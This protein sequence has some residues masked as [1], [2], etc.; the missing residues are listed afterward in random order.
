LNWVGLSLE[1]ADLGARLR[2]R[3][4]L[5]TPDA[6]ILATAIHSRATGFIGNDLRLSR[7]TEIDTMVLA[8]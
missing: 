7:V 5:K 3:Y 1:I 8:S 2:A 4:G 6:I